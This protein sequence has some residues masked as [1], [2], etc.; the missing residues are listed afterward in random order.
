MAVTREVG[1]V[2]VERA[3]CA[4]RDYLSSV[5]ADVDPMLPAAALSA[6]D[7]APPHLPEDLLKRYA[8][9]QPAYGRDNSR[10]Y[11]WG[12]GFRA[13][14]NHGL[15]ANPRVRG[16]WRPKEAELLAEHPGRY[17]RRLMV[18]LT[19]GSQLE[20][21]SRVADRE[22]DPL[23]DAA[24]GLLLESQPMAENDVATWIAATDPWGDTFALWVLTSYP[25]AHARLRDL[26]FALAVRYGQVALRDGA[27]RGTRFPF[28]QEPLIS[29]SAH[30]GTALWRLGI[31][32][33][34]LP[35][36]LDSV[37][38]GQQLDGGWADPGQPSDLLT[39]LAAAELLGTLDPR[40]DPTP[41]VDYFER[42]QE[43]DGW[44]RALNP[45]VPWLTGAIGNW[46]ERSERP[47]TARFQW[48]ELPVWSRDRTTRLPTMAVFDELAVALASIHGLAES[49]LEVAFIDLAG[50]GAF[51]NRYGMDAGDAALAAYAAAL[52]R[53]PRSMTIRQGGDEL[54]VLG[55]PGE[56]GVLDPLLRR[57]MS[58]W[59]DAAEDVGVP[60]GEVV[61]R[62]LLTS[63]PSG[64]LRRMRGEL[65]A[66]IGPLKKAVE[67]PRPDGILVWL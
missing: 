2:A 30:L 63:G 66:A 37:A 3:R 16:F 42:R 6:T 67:D 24:R 64:D 20:Y 59:Q 11:R 48:P 18:P 47:F 43:P 49:S 23:A 56:R 32:P 41:V 55:V 36:L 15:Y 60:R 22:S 10:R 28:W 27:V 4:L 57:F 45:E 21:W 50:F 9:R 7:L 31:Y 19:L 1:S 58:D 39:T 38:A 54:L 51:N 17:A 44:W 8:L 52:L 14:P 25:L 35:R 53:L 65:G 40:F 34:L 12:L 29:A 46:I 5:D 13:E 33:S 26:V 62:V 61:P